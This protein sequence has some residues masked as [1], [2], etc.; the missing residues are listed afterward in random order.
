MPKLNDVKETALYVDNLE[1]A[2]KFYREVLGLQTIVE[3]DRFCAF[4]VESKHVLLLFI[5][6]ASVTD[7]ELP[8]GTIPPH[9]GSGP[10][11][12]GFSIDTQE[13]PAW[14]EHF[15]AKGVKIEGR[16]TWPKGGKSIYFR[17]PDG[18]LLELLTP[19]VW[20]IY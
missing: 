12:A 4:S 7:T 8:G 10:L 16:V 9:D 3:Q 14:E 6:G 19:G 5:R 1:R 18:H 15:A 17:D 20:D 13:L 11:H 2:K